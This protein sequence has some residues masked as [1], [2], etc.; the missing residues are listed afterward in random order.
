MTTRPDTTT[1]D[2]YR[3]YLLY[4]DCWKRTENC[5][6]ADRAAGILLVGGRCIQVLKCSRSP[7]MHLLEMMQRHPSIGR[8]SLSIAIGTPTCPT[9][10]NVRCER[11][12][13]VGDHVHSIASLRLV[14]CFRC[15]HLNPW[16]PEKVVSSYFK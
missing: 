7:S 13:I 3:V 2:A 6:S 1:V 11:P 5:E 10:L 4:N 12:Y 15:Y 14:E 16:K 8:A 9:W